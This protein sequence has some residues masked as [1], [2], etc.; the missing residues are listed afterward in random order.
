MRKKSFRRKNI[1]ALIL[2]AEGFNETWLTSC[3]AELRDN[4]L[5]AVVVGLRPGPV[6]GQH[7]MVIQTDR[8]FGEIRDCQPKL[9]ALAD[10]KHCIYKLLSE[11]KVHRLIKATIQSGGRVAATPESET[12]LKRIGR[13][14]PAQFE[15]FIWQGLTPAPDYA[16]TLVHALGA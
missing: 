1:S 15:H 14:T 2:L 8:Y 9:L 12:I 13:L 4:G 5:D 7:G 11:P 6:S 3:V 16:R 10:G